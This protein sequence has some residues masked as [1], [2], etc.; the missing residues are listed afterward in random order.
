VVAE[1]TGEVLYWDLSLLDLQVGHDTQPRGRFPDA[2]SRAM[3]SIA[4]DDRGASPNNRAAEMLRLGAA[5]YS[6]D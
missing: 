3:A 6:E 5:R 2:V 4:E 1:D